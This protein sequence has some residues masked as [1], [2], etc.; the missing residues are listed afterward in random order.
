VNVFAKVKERLS[1]T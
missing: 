1:M